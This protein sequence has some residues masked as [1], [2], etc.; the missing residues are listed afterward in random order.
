[1]FLRTLILHAGLSGG[2]TR[3]SGRP[4]IANSKYDDPNNADRGALP[5][6]FASASKET[7]TPAVNSASVGSSVSHVPS[8][9]ISS[10]SAPPSAG[11]SSTE[12]PKRRLEDDS[13]DELEFSTSSQLAHLKF[14]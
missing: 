10:V 8:S 7:S 1:M 3:V 11:P 12:S 14:Y 2:K 5:R 6:M 9:S 4:R 13:D